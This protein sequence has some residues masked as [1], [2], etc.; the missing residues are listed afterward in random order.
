VKPIIADHCT[1]IV[2]EFTWGPVY[3]DRTA[4]YR[5]PGPDPDGSLDDA[6]C[7]EHYAWW[8]GPCASPIR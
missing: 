5:L 3:C 6:L 2:A 7:E 8:R 4:L 1:A